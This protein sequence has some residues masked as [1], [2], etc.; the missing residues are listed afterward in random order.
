M[1]TFTGITI[2]T[3]LLGMFIVR[4]WLVLFFV[5][6]AILIVIG[7][8]TSGW[9]TALVLTFLDAIITGQWADFNERWVYACMFFAVATS[10]YMCIV[11]SI[12][13]LATRFLRS[14]FLK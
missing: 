8:I 7:I 12:F 6:Q 13:S 10:V 4:Y 14:I 1:L 5:W 3:V 11:Y 9:V 2:L